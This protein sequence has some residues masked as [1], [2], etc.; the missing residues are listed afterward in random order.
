MPKQTHSQNT[1]TEAAEAPAPPPPQPTRP[2]RAAYGASDLAM[3]SRI[4]KLKS[5][6]DEEFL[7]A[8]LE[9]S[10]R[11]T[12]RS[13]AELA[14][15]LSRKL[16][17]APWLPLPQEW[18]SEYEVL[19][20][21]FRLAAEGGWQFDFLRTLAMRFEHNGIHSP[22]DFLTVAS[23]AFDHFDD[24]VESAVSVLKNNPHTVRNEIQEAIRNHPDLIS[25]K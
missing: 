8:L 22:E 1:G 10:L 18:P 13:M 19:R 23:E 16:V 20:Q 15:T 6:E 24:E 3:L 2:P 21:L 12:H 25:Q 7:H 14:F 11:Q 9:G 4:I 5:D 17:G